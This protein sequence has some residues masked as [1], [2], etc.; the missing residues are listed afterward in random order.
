MRKA[1]RYTDEQI[2]FIKANVLGRGNQELTDMFNERFNENITK[3]QMN[4]IKKNRGLNS[5]L[6]GH[7]KKGQKAWNSGMKG[8]QIGGKE[9]QF[10]KGQIPINHR[11]VG[12]ERVNVEGY[13]EIKIAEKKWELKHRHI[14]EKEHGKIP[15]SHAVIFADGNKSN[16]DL[17]NLILVSRKQLALLNKHKLIKDD[18]ELTRSGIIVADIYGKIG[19]RKKR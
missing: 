2:E 6:T 10:K 7:F 4:T 18:A 13:A 14:Y 19:E 9:T 12:S 11:P 17:D 16:L 8:L 15:K 3:Q 5:G 1:H